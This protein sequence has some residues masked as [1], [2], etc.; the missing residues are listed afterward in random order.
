MWNSTTTSV[1][2]VGGYCKWQLSFFCFDEILYIF[3]FKI[4]IISPFHC[5]LVGDQVCFLYWSQ[6]A[7][8]DS[9]SFVGNILSS[10]MWHLIHSPVPIHIG[11]ITE[12]KI[13]THC[14]PSSPIID[15]PFACSEAI[16]TKK[17]TM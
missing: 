1:K 2:N 17:T 4:V 3:F 13:L 12:T 7:L 10:V 9:L 8:M 14:A 5:A 15:T 16:F 6:L 11:V